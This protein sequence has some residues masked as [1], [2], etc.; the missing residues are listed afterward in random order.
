MVR[1]KYST[2]VLYNEQESGGNGSVVGDGTGQ[3]SISPYMPFE[4]WWEDIAWEG[5]N[6][7]DAD[8]NGDGEVNRADYDYYIL[9]E[10]WKGDDGED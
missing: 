6:Y 3:G 1:R 5:E 4:E 7:P 8:Y 9:H 10:L 2:P